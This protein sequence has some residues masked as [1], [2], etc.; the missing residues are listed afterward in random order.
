MFYIFKCYVQYIYAIL[1]S[2]LQ[3]ALL[4]LG[5]VVF[6]SFQKLYSILRNSNFTILES[7]ISRRPQMPK[8]ET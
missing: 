5:K 1:F 8:H 7:E 2:I 3:E 6:N 4:K